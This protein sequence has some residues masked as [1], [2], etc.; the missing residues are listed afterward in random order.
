[1]R[2]QEF[3]KEYEDLETAK[4]AIIATVSGLAVDNERDAQLIDRI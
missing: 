1:M 4:Q 2:A 3:L